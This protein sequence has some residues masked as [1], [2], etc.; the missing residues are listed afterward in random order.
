VRAQPGAAASAPADALP[1]ALLGWVL[2]CTFVYSALFGAGSLLYGRTAPFFA[3]LAVFVLT[4]LGMW[5]VLR[6]FW[7][8]AR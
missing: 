3:W 1:Q 8:A 7:P 5:R 4:G 2:G 6:G